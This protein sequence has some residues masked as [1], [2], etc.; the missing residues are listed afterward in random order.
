MANLLGGS[1][2]QPGASAQPNKIENI[3]DD[4]FASLRAYVKAPAPGQPAMVDQSVQLLAELYQTM[5][6][7][8]TAVRGGMA[9]P[10]TEVPNKVRAEAGR[11]PE[12]IRSMLNTLVAT[13]V[14]Q[15]LGA[16]RD[17]LGNALRASVSDFCAQAITGRYPFTK[18]SERNVTQDDFA[19]LFSPGGL[20]DDFFQ[21]SLLQYVDTSTKP[22][23]FRQ[24]GGGQMGDKGEGS[25]ALLQFQRAQ[26]IRDTLFRNG[27]KTPALRLDFKPLE[28]DAS[29]TQ[30]ILDID[31]QTVKYAHGPSVPMS[32]TWPGTAARGQVRISLS[33]Q[34]AGGT[35]GAV[36]EGPWALFRM[37][38]KVQIENAGQPERFKAIFVIDGR[39]A[40]FEVTTSSVL[41][42]FRM[43]ELQ[44][45]AC[46]GKL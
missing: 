32:V 10:Q 33:P 28:M 25:G 26:A 12:P 44:S 15:A 20:M 16:T 2:P 17:N 31:G 43:T 42:P 41:N 39:K 19:R 40:V 4:K 35:S 38:D 37:F 24:V 29:I 9:P 13:G 11:L 46:P 14:T 27:G 30:F 7:T 34:S 22:W 8:E 45:F 1:K 21:R 36:F 5:S 3:V 18:G 6:A 23:S